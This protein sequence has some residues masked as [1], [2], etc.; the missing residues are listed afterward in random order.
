VIGPNQTL[1]I[2]TN[3]LPPTGSLGF[4]IRARGRGELAVQP[5][6]TT[7]V[8]VATPSQRRPYVVTH[9]LRGASTF[10][11]LILP[12][13]TFALGDGPR[14][15]ERVEMTASDDAAIEIDCIVP[16]VVE[17]NGGS[18]APAPVP[19]PSVPR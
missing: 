2:V 9:E 14:R 3:D 5:F 19:V 4:M 1:S 6:S 13:G 15:I 8:A 16:Y 12:D 18:V 11:D 17:G 10:V 7:G